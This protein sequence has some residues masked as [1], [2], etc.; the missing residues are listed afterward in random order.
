MKTSV[1]AASITI[2]VHRICS[3]YLEMPGLR[4]TSA[5]AQRLLGV[6]AAVCTHALDL[7]VE[8]GFLRL[9]PTDQYVRVTD[10][11]VV[12]PFRMAKVS[13]VQ[14]RTDQKVS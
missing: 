13:S 3:E 4:L 9:T 2:P 5:Q 12:P 6:E 14:A 8:A 7:L 10:G 11:L 1:A